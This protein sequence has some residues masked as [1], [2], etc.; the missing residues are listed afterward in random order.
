MNHPTTAI[1]PHFN[2]GEHIAKAVHSLFQ[3]HWQPS[4]VIIVDDCSTDGSKEVIRSLSKKPHIR[5]IFLKR[6]VGASEAFNVGIRE[7]KTKYV[8][9][10]AADEESFPDCYPHA[11]SMLDHYPAGLCCGEIEWVREDGIVWMVGRKMPRLSS[12]IPKQD[13]L[14]IVKSGA[15]LGGYTG[16]IWRRDCLLNIGLNPTNVGPFSDWFCLHAVAFRFGLCFIPKPMSR[17]NEHRN[18]GYFRALQNRPALDEAI[19]NLADKLS[20]PEF[21]DISDHIVRSG[22]LA[23]IGPIRVIVPLLKNRLHRRFLNAAFLR[24]WLVRTAESFAGNYLPIQVTKLA[25]K[26]YEK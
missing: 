4:E 6:N 3:S 16:S 8:T 14:K 12:Y 25:L 20:S 2:H 22:A 18:S 26:F 9:L 17:F 5:I 7:A 10:L 15:N 1:I 24:N 23:K 21:K 13:V 11:E 19:G